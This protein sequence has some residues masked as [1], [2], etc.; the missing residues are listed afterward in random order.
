MMLNQIG[1]KKTTNHL[2]SFVAFDLTRSVPFVMIAR[3]VASLQSNSLKYLKL[4]PTKVMRVKDHLL[5]Y[6][7]SFIYENKIE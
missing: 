3:K 7:K 4:D 6:S 1:K 5:N 2:T